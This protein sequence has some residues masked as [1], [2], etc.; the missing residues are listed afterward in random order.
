MKHNYILHEICIIYY[1]KYKSGSRRRARR[2]SNPSFLT[3]ESS[4]VRFLCRAPAEVGL[5][6][7]FFLFYTDERKP[8]EK[9]WKLEE[10][11]A[12]FGILGA[13]STAPLIPLNTIECTGG[14]VHR[15]P[16]GFQLGLLDA[17]RGASVSDC[18]CFSSLGSL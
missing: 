13:K 3:S 12:S 11:L 7:I 17:P 18:Y 16:G 10:K 15:V 8:P 1:M 9:K 2:C 4:L 5:F 6:F 14:N